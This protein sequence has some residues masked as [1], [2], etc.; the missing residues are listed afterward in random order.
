MFANGVSDHQI[1]AYQDEIDKY[2]EKDD[3]LI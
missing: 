3:D 2:N 1:K